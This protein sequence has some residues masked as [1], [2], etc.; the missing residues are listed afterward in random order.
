MT[1]ISNMVE[2]RFAIDRLEIAKS[3]AVIILAHNEASVIE[4]TI[5]SILRVLDPQDV[6]YIIADNCS[7]STASRAV[8]AGAVVWERLTDCPDGKG[9]AL[10][11]F[12][13]QA[14]DL[15][16][17]F[18]L[19]VILDADNQV[20][21]GFLREI[22]AGYQ[23]EGLMQCFVQ[24]IG[25]QESSL[26][27]LIALSEIHEQKTIDGIRTRFGW[28]VRLRGTGMV[29]TH[30]LLKMAAK[31][32]ET[33]VE[34]I[35]LTLLFVSHGIRIQR[36]ERISVYDPKPCESK[37]ASQQRARWFRGQWVAFWQCRREVTM[38][39]KQGPSGWFLLS[40]LFLKPRWL[41]NLILLLLALSLAQYSRIL[42]A[43]FLA[44]VLFDIV[45]LG[46][47]ILLSTERKRF[48]Q[49]ILHVPA[50]IIMWIRSF[51]LAFKKSPW[52]RARD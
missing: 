42:A 26:S 2:T 43:L 34:D 23:G 44:S 11:W 46:W 28:S 13:D 52:L 35:V 17:H 45:C 19:I 10:K 36:N 25:Y 48:I 15:L 16:E 5:Q 6:V 20:P 1:L 24:P 33:E 7:D 40:S 30:R 50:F 49:A 22:K 8:R 27:T 12:V 9:T 47:T 29:M 31:M 39:L 3:A 41:I 37:L 32:I 18:D 4:L 21:Q 14:G 51:L 38:L